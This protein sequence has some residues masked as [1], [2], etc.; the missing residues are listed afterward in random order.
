MD[1]TVICLVGIKAVLFDLH[2]SLAYAENDVSEEKISD[3]LFRRGYEVSPQ[4]LRASWAFVAFVDY[5]KYGY[6]SWRS[7]FRRILK[8]L[9]VRV[10]KETLSEIVELLE[11]RHYQLYPD[12]AEAV[13][14]AKQSGMKTAIVT[15]IAHFQFQ[16]AVKPLKEYFDFIMTGFEAG[17]DKTNPWMY[18][19]VLEILRVEPQEAAMIGDN[20]DIDVD[21]PKRLGMHTIFL[22]RTGQN[23][24][25]RAADA[26]AYSLPEAVKTA[27]R[28]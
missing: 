18:K 22:D 12:A 19:R 9:K 11:R 14:K 13:V 27:L 26:I 16:R 3:L 8:R 23:A 2:G 28:M 7:Y 25:P 24:K 20:A 10:D 4:Q 5:P 21:L 15:T 17:C 6:K 1:L